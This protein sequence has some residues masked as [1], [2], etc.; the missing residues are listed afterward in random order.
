MKENIV[1]TRSLP[2]GRKPTHRL[3]RVVGD[4][5]NAIWTPIGAAWPNKDGHGFSINCEALPLSGRIVMRTI[6]M[7]P[8]A[9]S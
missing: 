5:E 7:R 8:T 9:A 4:G 6:T 1:T 3:F 2:L